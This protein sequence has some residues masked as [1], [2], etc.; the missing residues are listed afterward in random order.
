[1]DSGIGGL[2]VLAALIKRRAGDRYIYYSDGAHLPYG[3]KSAEELERIALKGVRVLTERGAQVVV[4][5]CNT[6]SVC[7]LDRVRKQVRPPVFGLIPRPELC[8]GKTLL[9]TTP[10]TALYLPKIG[11]NVALLTPTNLARI[12]D[13]EYPLAEATRC[14]LSPLLSPYEGCE[15]VYLGCSH[16]LYARP[17]F[18]AL[19]PQAKIYDGCEMLA[20]L[21]SAVLP[22]EGSRDPTVDFL[23]GGRKE[24]ERYYR[25][26]RRLLD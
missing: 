18:K 7:A 20:A 13:E 2:N 21:V 23:F 1:M 22:S 19:L 4:F 14:Y 5:G 26:L 8:N 6:L 3:D 12:I 25:I 11:E 15:S 16:Y 10:A 17:L 24:E 9:L